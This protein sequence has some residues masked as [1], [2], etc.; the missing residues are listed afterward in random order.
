MVEADFSKMQAQYYLDTEHHLDVKANLMD[1]GA[2][3]V[4]LVAFFGLA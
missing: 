3:I 4:R 1:F 2:E